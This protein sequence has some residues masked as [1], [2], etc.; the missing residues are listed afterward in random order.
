MDRRYGRPHSHSSPSLPHQLDGAQQSAASPAPSPHPPRTHSHGAV[1]SHFLAQPNNAYGDQTWM[2]FLR[3]SGAEPDSTQP[4]HPQQLYQQQVLQQQQR[5]QHQQARMQ[6]QIDAPL[7]TNRRLPPLP[8]ENYSR[9]VRFA[10]ATRPYPNDTST[11]PADRKRRLTAAESPMRRPEGRRTHEGSASSSSGAGRSAENPIV[12]D[13]S[14][15][16]SPATRPP[17]PQQ[18]P[19]QSSLHAGPGSARR[20]SE[21]VLPQWQPDS[22]VTHCFVCGSQFTFFYRKHHCRK[23]GRVVC[24][25][26]SPHR[27][28][29]PR[30]FIVHPPADN[31]NMIDLTADDDDSA[32][33]AFGP[34]RNP[35]LGGGE[36]VRVCNPCVPDPNY[37]PPPP[38]TPGAIPDYPQFSPPGHQ[39]YSLGPSPLNS[40]Q[41]RGHRSSQSVNNSAQTVGYGQTPRSRDPLMDR[42]VSY[43]GSTHGTDM[44]RPTQPPQP[45][46]DQ[47]SAVDYW[48]NAPSRPH[49]T[50]ASSAA[51]RPPLHS[52]IDAG[53]MTPSMIR[54][55]A[56]SQGTLAPSAP[57]QAP[58]QPQP[59]PR[60]QIAE[61]DECPIC[62]NEL[63]PK[64]P[65]DDEIAR[66]Q[67][68]EQCI[69][70]HSGSPPPVSTEQTSQSLP[71]QRSRGM[72]SAATPIG[73]GEG[74]SNGN[75]LSMSARGMYPYTATEKDCLDEDGNEAECVIC[76]EEF[77]AGV[78]MARLVC[79]CKFHEE[80]IR[81]WWDK[82]GRGACPTHQL[83]Y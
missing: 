43:H 83:Q 81:Q 30:Q 4:S 24:A 39:P 23:C 64:G 54:R 19:S 17:P 40:G 46:Y 27:I 10:F 41:P 34:F 74:A 57:V 29:I 80:C 31:P 70:I 63:P 1:A 5:Q 73:N 36:E 3:E 7:N 66:I 75:R 2:D 8:H 50:L 11:S 45:G 82:K 25:A 20:G 72:S 51:V 60:R 78:K 65:N 49:P 71:N 44:W 47:P 35:A 69:A 53:S 59:A 61:E 33:S 55:L 12:L 62:G 52:Q 68:V 16:P 14:P 48:S 6:A 79:W 28:T 13:S 32:M 56:F 22:D 37:S 18:Y 77:E 42:R 9:D 21:F 67:H 38:Y 76:F 58:Q 26:C 15:V